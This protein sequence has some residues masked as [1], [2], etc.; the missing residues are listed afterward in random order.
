MFLQKL[1]PVSDVAVEMLPGD[2]QT[3]EDAVD[4]A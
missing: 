4:P 2:R 3:Q 1:H